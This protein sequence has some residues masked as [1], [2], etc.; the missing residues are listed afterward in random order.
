[1]KAFIIIISIIAFW[2]IFLT[3]AS[4][5]VDIMKKSAIEAGV[6][7]NDGKA[8]RVTLIEWRENENTDKRAVN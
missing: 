2:G 7:T 3:F 8:Y 5:G 4:I 1:M 6:F